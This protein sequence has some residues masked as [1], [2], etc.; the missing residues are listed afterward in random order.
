[1]ELDLSDVKEMN[2]DPSEQQVFRLQPGDVLISEGAGSLA[3][4][5]A[6]AV[7]EGDPP[8]V[9]FQSTLLRLRPRADVDPH[10]VAWWARA[11]YSS[12]EF[13]R[14]ATGAS[15]YHLGAERFRAIRAWI[16]ATLGNNCFYDPR[17]TISAE[18]GQRRMSV[19]QVRDEAKQEIA[20]WL[21]MTGEPSDRFDELLGS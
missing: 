17:Q 20:D 15:I 14:F 19:A 3:A 5:G 6:S 16:P 13:A 8:E 21:E 2:F 7:H 1:M 9:C 11:M 12:G 4:V 10:F 18:A